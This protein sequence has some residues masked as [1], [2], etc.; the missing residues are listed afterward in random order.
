MLNDSPLDTGSVFQRRSSKTIALPVKDSLRLVMCSPL[1]VS[2]ESAAVEVRNAE[3]TTCVPL[4]AVSVA[5]P[6]LPWPVLIVAEL[7]GLSNLIVSG[8]VAGLPLA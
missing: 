6:P 7:I 3:P 1:T 5:V 2:G 8:P 4:K